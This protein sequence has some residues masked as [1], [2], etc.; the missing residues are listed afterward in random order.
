MQRATISGLV[1]AAV[2][3]A[4]LLFSALPEAHAG[5]INP[6]DVS[7]PCKVSARAHTFPVVY[8]GA[9]RQNPDGTLYP[10]DAIN[11][12]IKWEMLNTCLSPRIADFRTD[13]A[14]TLAYA[15]VVRGEDG[16]GRT[17]PGPDPI[18]QETW[19]KEPSWE[20]VGTT[21]RSDTLP[22]CQDYRDGNR[23]EPRFG[24]PYA[25]GSRER[26]FLTH[27][28]P[29]CGGKPNEDFPVEEDYDTPSYTY[30][31]SKKGFTTITTNCRL[32]KVPSPIISGVLGTDM[33]KKYDGTKKGEPQYAYCSRTTDK[34]ISLSSILKCGFNPNGILVCKGSWGYD[35][36]TLFGIWNQQQQTEHCAR[37]DTECRHHLEDEESIENFKSEVMRRCSN[38]PAHQGCVYGRIN[39]DLE[40]DTRVCNTDFFEGGP[41]R[42][43]P[44]K[45]NTHL[46]EPDSCDMPYFTEY[47]LDR[48]NREKGKNDPEIPVLETR[49]LTD[50]GS[51]IYIPEPVKDRKWDVLPRTDECRPDIEASMEH[52]SGGGVPGVVHCTSNPNHFGKICMEPGMPRTGFQKGDYILPSNHFSKMDIGY[53]AP[54]RD[55]CVKQD[56]TFSLTVIGTERICWKENESIICEFKE[57]K[58]TVRTP[59]EIRDPNP[60]PFFSNPVIHDLDDLPSRNL[61]G[62]YYAWDVPSI[63]MDPHLLFRDQRNGTLTM[64]TRQ[65]GAPLERLFKHSCED[66]AC[67]FNATT[68]HSQ[69]K[70]FGSVNGDYVSIHRPEG[71]HK[72]GN[73]TFT[74]DLR[75]FNLGREISLT[76]PKTWLLIVDYDPRFEEDRYQYTILNSP[77]SNAVEKEKAIGLSYLGSYGG[78]PDDE[79]GIHDHRRAKINAANLTVQV[80]SRP[81]VENVT[82]TAKVAGGEGLEKMLAEIHPSVTERVELEEDVPESSI[83]SESTGAA[84]FEKFGLGRLA[85][86]YHDNLGDRWNSIRAVIGNAT[87]FS[88]DFAGYDSTDLGQSTYMYVTAYVT[89]QLNVTAFRADGSHD[90]GV[91]VEAKV[92]P[93]IDANHT[94][95]LPDYVHGHLNLADEVE[96]R[97]LDI[98]DN[99]LNFTLI[100]GQ[101]APYFENHTFTPYPYPPRITD[102]RLARG[103]AMMQISDIYDI[104]NHGAGDG[105]VHRDLNRPII[106]IIPDANVLLDITDRTSFTRFRM[107]EAIETDG[108]YNI[109]ITATDGERTITHAWNLPPLNFDSPV[110][111]P[112]SMRNGTELSFSRNF[113][114]INIKAPPYFGEITKVYADGEFVTSKCVPECSIT[115]EKNA[116]VTV[117]NKWGGTAEVKVAVPKRVVTGTPGSVSVAYFD[118]VLPMGILLVV[119]AAAIIGFLKYTRTR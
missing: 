108:I 1:L 59:A 31:S 79:P 103:F 61:D 18:F 115:L 48:Y 72:L 101:S 118:N 95:W 8:E 2:L 30:K 20:E 56:H 87:I 104:T 19:K 89:T 98:I 54:I 11:F 49:L 40:Y 35:R 106:T 116:T 51:R 5:H 110:S 23:K 42:I 45:N 71:L 34:C 76:H 41:V 77:G 24:E 86:T 46:P 111:F 97:G 81:L 7:L 58:V 50:N 22:R 3:G 99:T 21:H 113:A 10:G 69:P 63:R 57:K 117:E 119:G 47:D 96:A 83:V 68:E 13:G 84:Q 9:E 37:D 4:G 75:V 64:E 88:K 39:A 28:K 17:G 26:S 16:N 94:M 52:G 93:I 12:I 44:T 14:Y 32:G 70:L 107:H 66:G 25:C 27:F 74:Y 38:L 60:V 100:V 6:K 92:Q 53:Q 15:E 114:T 73:H 90:P 29:S 109:T 36:K 65:H 78:G 105:G 43:I 80:Y 67:A 85:L 82:T 91:H 112:I 102:E 55:S 33:Y 62:T